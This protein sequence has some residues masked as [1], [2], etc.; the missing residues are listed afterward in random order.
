MRNSLSVQ[1]RCVECLR[2]FVIATKLVA[3]RDVT[4]LSEEVCKTK[5]TH[6]AKTTNHEKF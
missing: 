1:P 5:I 4:E 3:K 6:V 2:V